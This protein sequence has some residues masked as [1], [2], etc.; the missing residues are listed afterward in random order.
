[1]QGDQK[2]GKHVHNGIFALFTEKL[3]ISDGIFVLLFMYL[4][5]VFS[6]LTTTK[7]L[8]SSHIRKFLKPFLFMFTVYYAKSET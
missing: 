4:S 6:R 8:N 1:M 7:L 2:V 3:L 5:M